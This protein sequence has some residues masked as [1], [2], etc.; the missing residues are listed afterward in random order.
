MRKAHL[1]HFFQLHKPKRLLVQPWING[2]QKSGS[3]AISENPSMQKAHLSHFFQLLEPKR[4]LVQPRINGDQK[5]GSA[6]ISE[7]P[8]MQKAHLSHFF[9]LLE[10]KRLLVQ[11]LACLIRLH[12]FRTGCYRFLQHHR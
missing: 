3:A 5:S 6:A 8:S 4:L 1:S 2:D 9:Q 11:P 7:N 10:P 12:S